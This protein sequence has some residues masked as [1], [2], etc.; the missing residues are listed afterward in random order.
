MLNRATESLSRRETLE[1]YS[2]LAHRLGIFW[3]KSELEDTSLR[4][5]EPDIYDQ[6]KRLVA[7]KKQVAALTLLP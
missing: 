3:L 1:L 4:F 7:K 5:L 6:L 2:P